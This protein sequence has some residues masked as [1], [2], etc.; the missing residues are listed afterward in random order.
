M[1][2][3]FLKAAFLAAVHSSIL[4]PVSS[5]IDHVIQHFSD[6]I[7]QL[8]G[9]NY[10][11]SLKLGNKKIYQIDLYFSSHNPMPLDDVRILIV[12]TT[13]MFLEDVNNNTYLKE[14]LTNFP[15]TANQ[16]DITIFFRGKNGKYASLP[17]IA[18]VSMH[19]GI[20]IY[21]KY[22]NGSFQTIEEES[23]E[24]ASKMIQ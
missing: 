16:I 10:T 11:T 17:D 4:F 12:K 15:L 21:Y 14:D 7:N 3:S 22:A 8:S 5:E 18:Q 2:R 24:K 19:N 23:F 13:Q 6:R 9:L 1:K 20:I